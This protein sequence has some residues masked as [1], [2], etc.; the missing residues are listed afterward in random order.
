ML[1][2]TTFKNNKISENAYADA[3]VQA[4]FE[5]ANEEVSDI[6]SSNSIQDSDL[7]VAKSKLAS[8]R[9]TET[10]EVRSGETETRAVTVDVI[11]EKDSSSSSEQDEAP[12]INAPLPET[13]AIT[14]ASEVVRKEPVI[15][16]Y[17]EICESYYHQM[18]HLE[19]MS[20]AALADLIENAKLEYVN[21]PED[22]RQ[23]LEYKSRMATKYFELVSALEE[24]VDRAVDNTLNDMKNKLLS[25]D[26]DVTIVEKM[27]NEYQAT[28]STRKNEI[29]SEILTKTQES[30]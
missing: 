23:T 18:E 2:F 16:S 25:Y 5:S 26:Y 29:L 9:S 13:T 28:K 10:P 12:L 3:K 24:M 17:D 14:V 27:G 11:E 19:E 8:E 21:T 30:M 22:I 15:L 6:L 20:E 1:G 4:I 7:I